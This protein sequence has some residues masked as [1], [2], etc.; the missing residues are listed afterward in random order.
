MQA[1]VDNH[2]L[3]FVPNPLFRDE[4]SVEI[5]QTAS[6]SSSFVLIVGRLKP[7]KAH[8]VLLDAFASLSPELANWRLAIVGDGKLEKELRS[9]A[10]ILGIAERIDWYGRVANPF[11]FYRAAKIFVLPSR[12]EGTPNA[13]LEAMICSLPVI[14]S[15][16][17]PGPLELVR[18][19]KTGLVVP[20]D[21]VVAL[22]GAIEL[23]A[24]NA[25]FRQRL[26]E[27][28]RRRVSDYELSRVLPIWES[29]I[30]L[31]GYDKKSSFSSNSKN[32]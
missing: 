10:T 27:A 29:V 24:Q 2:K 17:S 14:V 11:V 32:F 4:T 30:G 12:R 19:R 3:A 31:E 1:Y 20:V 22:A 18:D 26:G 23:L 8:N 9:Q 5:Q 6:L 28:A 13:L 7:A 25:E 21:D 15:D 16:V